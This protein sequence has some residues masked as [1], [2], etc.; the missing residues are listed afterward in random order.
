[1]KNGDSLMLPR[2]VKIPVAQKLL[3]SISRPKIYDL[4]QTG[5][6]V[7]LHIDKSSFITM[8][9]ID[10]LISGAIETTGETRPNPRPR[11]QSASAAA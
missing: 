8:D 3:G 2:I 11:K 4:I 5:R 9:S 7:L 10:A 6:L 1:M